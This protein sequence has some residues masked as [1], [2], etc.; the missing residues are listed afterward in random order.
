MFR[1][2][3]V[4]ILEHELQLFILKVCSFLLKNAT[5]KGI[6]RFAHGLG[7]M[8]FLF[9]GR[10]RRAAISGLSFAFNGSMDHEQVKKLTRECFVSMAKSGCEIG[11]FVK[12]PRLIRDSVTIEGER[13]LLEGLARG[14]GV[15]LVS[16]HFGNFPLMLGRLCLEGYKTS[17]IMRPLKD[18]RIEQFLAGE[19]RRIGLTPIYSIPRAECVKLALR[20]LRRNELLFIPSDQNF[21][22]GGVFVDFFNRKAAT[23]TG[24][25]VFAERTGAAI[26]PCFIVRHPDNTHTIHIEPVLEPVAAESQEAY[27]QGTLQKI[28][29]VIERYI[30]Q[31]PQEWTWIHRRWKSRPKTAAPVRA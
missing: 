29:D 20:T 25:A 24:P 12:K 27:I 28:T 17:V 18:N 13:Y 5:R 8:L 26:I 15:I 2:R 3:F 10:H 23:A 30:R 22:T 19:V 16:A 1:K 4:K 11:F 7:T 31:Y 6:Y 21:G 14:K 9:D